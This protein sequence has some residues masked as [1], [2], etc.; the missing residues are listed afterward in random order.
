MTPYSDYKTWKQPPL[1]LRVVLGHRVRVADPESDVT[2]TPVPSDPPDSLPQTPTPP[3]DDPQTVGRRGGGVDDREG[4]P[5][6][7]DAETPGTSAVTGPYTGK[8]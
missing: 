2:T 8:S 1:W 4:P 5:A 7:R 3:S 6:G